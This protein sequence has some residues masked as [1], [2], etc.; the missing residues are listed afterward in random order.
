MPRDV[1]VSCI[2]NLITRRFLY[3]GWISNDASEDADVTIAAVNQ[4]ASIPPTL[5]ASFLRTYLFGAGNID[6]I[7]IQR[8]G[9]IDDECRNSL[10]DERRLC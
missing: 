3:Q 2:T 7:F 10:S 4:G 5:I 8:T 6:L 9:V 1:T